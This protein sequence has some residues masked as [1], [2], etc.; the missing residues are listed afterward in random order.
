MKIIIT[1]I[2]DT[3]D[4]TS[5]DINTQG[6]IYNCVTV[7]NIQQTYNKTFQL[8]CMKDQFQSVLDVIANMMY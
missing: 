1:W 4:S 6:H 5:E 3:R 8:Y 7:I 2:R